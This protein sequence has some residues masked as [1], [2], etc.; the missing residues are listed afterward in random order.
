MSSPT[1]GTT[2]NSQEHQTYKG[3]CHCGFVTYTVRLNLATPDPATGAILTKC[4]CTI[5]LKGGGTLATPEAGS[6]KLLTPARGMEALTDYTF[7]SKQ[8]HYRFCPKCGVRCFLNGFFEVAGQRVEI[9]RINVLT[10]DQTAGGGSLPELK[11]IKV[12]YLPGRDDQ[13]TR[14]MADQPYKGGVW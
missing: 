1:T 7:N 8:I 9:W 6:F 2:R 13:R 11:D 12:K 3:S 4:N 10:L 5:C 14:G